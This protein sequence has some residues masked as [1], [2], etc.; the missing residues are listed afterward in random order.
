MTICHTGGCGSP[1]HTIAWM[2]TPIAESDATEAAA[3]W[4]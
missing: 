1:I 4:M 3:V 2:R